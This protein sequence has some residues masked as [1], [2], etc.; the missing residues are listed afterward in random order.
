VSFKVSQYRFELVI[1][2]VVAGWAPALRLGSLANLTKERTEGV[3][4][5]ASLVIPN[6]FGQLHI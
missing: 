2:S 1:E 3:E 4:G 6:W 5:K